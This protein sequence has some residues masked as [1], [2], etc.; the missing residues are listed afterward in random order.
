MLWGMLLGYEG[1]LG[2]ARGGYGCMIGYG[3]GTSYK[4]GDLTLCG[5]VR[6]LNMGEHKRILPIGY[7]RNAR[8]GLLCVG[9]WCAR[10]QELS[11]VSLWALAQFVVLLDIRR[12]YVKGLW[13][14]NVDNGKGC[15]GCGLEV[16]RGDMGLL[17]TN[18][19]S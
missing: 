2:C 9:L 1:S 15:E 7:S 16:Q 5:V 4:D 17:E 19:G 14:R 18:G 13:V 6:C 8:Q 12:G 10:L 11:N 3:Y